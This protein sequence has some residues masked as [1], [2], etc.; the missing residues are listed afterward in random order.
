MK[1]SKI[2]K[3]FTGI[4]LCATLAVVGIFGGL[5]TGNIFGKG[6]LNF[7]EDVSSPQDE[8]PKQDLED[9]E[10][11]YKV[12]SLPTT[13]DKNLP[14][15]AETN[16]TYDPQLPRANYS[17][18]YGVDKSNGRYR[19]YP[20][21]KGAT[22]NDNRTFYAGTTLRMHILLQGA[23]IT[24]VDVNDTDLEINKDYTVYVRNGVVNLDINYKITESVKHLGVC[25]YVDLNFTGVMA[26]FYVQ[27]FWLDKFEEI[28]FS[29]ADPSWNAEKH[30]LTM[31]GT[32]GGGLIEIDKILNLQLREGQTIYCSFK[33]IEGKVSTV[34][35][36]SFSFEFLKNGSIDHSDRFYIDYR[37]NG[38]LLKDT[39]KK[40]DETFAASFNGILLNWWF[41][42]DS[43]T[44]DNCVY[45]IKIFTWYDSFYKDIELP[46]E[47]EGWDAE[48]HQL[49]MNGTYNGGLTRLASLDFQLKE[50][51][52]LYCSFKHLG[53]TFS[54]TQSCSF[55]FEF[56]KNGNVDYADRYYI[57][58]R[59]DGTALKDNIIVIDEAFA[60]KFNGM[61]LHWWVGIDSVTFTNCTYEIHI[62]TWQ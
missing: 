26:N 30:Q 9:F 18:K 43:V 14:T 56:L 31:N 33:L 48:T 36:C 51:Q 8:L 32:F 20:K 23:N 17:A 39:T 62:Y 37:L 40:V 6:N 61:S 47:A 49:T 44:F 59:F 41:G 24:G 45:E 29:I 50:G 13:E 19:I 22:W 15:E 52:K 16:N 34:A 42:V 21:V 57:D 5:F 46:I 53:G 1:K 3:I 11:D 38:A 60:S 4:T 28:D 55:S 25:S 10:E 2:W 7:A 27:S 54:T 35:G 12:P 58:Y